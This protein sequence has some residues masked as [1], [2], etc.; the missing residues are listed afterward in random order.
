[1]REFQE[2]PE[3]FIAK[4]LEERQREK[5]R[6]VGGFR[7]RVFSTEVGNLPR[8]KDFEMLIKLQEERVARLREFQKNPERYTTKKVEEEVAHDEL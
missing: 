2:D 7:E 8:S 1:M 6:G 4:R 5:K 3:D